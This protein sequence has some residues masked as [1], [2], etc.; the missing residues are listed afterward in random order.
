MARILTR[1]ETAD[2]LGIPWNQIRYH[3]MVALRSKLA[4]AYAPSTANKMLAAVRGVLKSA[5][6]LETIDTDAPTPGRSR[7]G[8]CG[9]LAC[10]PAGALTAGEIRALFD[11]CSADPTPAGSRD[12]AAFAMLFGAGLRRSEAVSVQLAD[13]APETGALTITGKGNRQRL[14]YATGGGK[15]AID[16]WRAD[17][18]EY[19]G[20]LLAPVNKDAAVQ[21]RPM[22]APGADESPQGPIQAGRDSP[23]LSPRSS[24]IFRERTARRRRRHR[25]GAAAGGASE[26]HDDGTLRPARGTGQEKGR[27]DAGGAVPGAVLRGLCTRVD[28]PQEITERIAS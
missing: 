12:A 11:V 20:A 17:R 4:E 13:Y 16:A 3:H 24:E 28:A 19:D 18:G 23:V 10:R 6:Q 21:P 26:S 14:V 15:E 25:G 1:D 27:G 8:Q 5:W 9:A 2:A 7:S 22:T